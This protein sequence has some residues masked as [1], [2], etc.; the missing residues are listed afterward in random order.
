MKVLTRSLHEMHRPLQLLQ[1]CNTY[2]AVMFSGLSVKDRR[3]RPIFV[4][5]LAVAGPGFSLL[6]VHG[7]RIRPTMSLKH[8]LILMETSSEQCRNVSSCIGWRQSFSNWE[9]LSAS[10]PMVL[11]RAAQAHP[12]TIVPYFFTLYARLEEATWC[13]VCDL[14]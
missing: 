10:S 9:N 1:M 13:S 7:N 11:T 14:A 3:T 8:C 12:S 2:G 4:M 6:K 5:F